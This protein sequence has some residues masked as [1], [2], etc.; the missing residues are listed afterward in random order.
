MRNLTFM[1]VALLLTGCSE[2][3]RSATTPAPK[4]AYVAATNIT[5]ADAKA[6]AAHF[7]EYYHSEPAAPADHA[8]ALRFECIGRA[9]G[10]SSLLVERMGL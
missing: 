6:A 5:E 3:E 4:A 8:D 2:A 9:R 7:C 10:G 1:L